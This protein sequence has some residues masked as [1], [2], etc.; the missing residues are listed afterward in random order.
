MMSKT[1]LALALIL[2]AASVYPSAVYRHNQEVNLTDNVEFRRPEKEQAPAQ[3]EAS[4]PVNEKQ[5]PTPQIIAHSPFVVAL[6]QVRVN[7]GLSPLS[8]SAELNAATQ[9]WANHLS[10]VGYYNSGSACSPHRCGHW[11][12]AAWAD[13]PA[14]P[15]QLWLNSPAHRNIILGNFTEVGFA[16]AYRGGIYIWIGELR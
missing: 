11:E 4:S 8:E 9:A 7:A 3:A 15:L 10:A 6:N 12:V 16:T 14:D 1:L 5:F 13:W 2:S